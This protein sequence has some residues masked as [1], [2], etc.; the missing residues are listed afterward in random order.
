MII[1]IVVAFTTHLNSKIPNINL[2]I[3]NNKLMLR[4][5]PLLQKKKTK[6]LYI[7]LKNTEIAGHK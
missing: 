4:K 2:Q 5:N 6:K 7:W 1:V 3:N